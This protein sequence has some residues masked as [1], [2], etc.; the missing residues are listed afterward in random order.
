MSN[1]KE[2]FWIP[3]ADLMTVLMII[4]LFISLGYMGLLQLQKRQQ[5]KIFEEYKQTKENLF[6]ELDS[7]FKNDFNRWNLELD[8]DLSIKF[9]NP[10]VLF[11]S[12]KSDITPK[13]K[14]ILTEFFP[15]YLSVILQ[16]KYRDKI[17]EIRIEGHTDTVPIHETNDPYIDNIK[18]SQDR[19][20]Q[21]LQFLRNLPCYKNLTQT[22]DQFLQFWLTANGLS[23]G[24]TLD[25]NKKLTIFSKQPIDKEKSRRVE[26]RIV[27]T[28]EGLVEKVLERL[29]N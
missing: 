28:S 4:F 12:G 18:L 26:F 29:K 8:K 14:E 21:V 23:Y 27:T 16:K 3:Y 7:T 10:E 2:N 20:R 6:Q 9:T 5:D 25:S 11:A 15:K 19:S 22:E 24:R 17:A 13:F 1:K